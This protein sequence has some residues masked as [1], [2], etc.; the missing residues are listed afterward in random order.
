MSE[1]NQIILIPHWIHETLRRHQLN[2]TDVLNFDALRR[3][4]S[5]S[6]L[7]GFM[8]LNQHSNKLGVTEDEGSS[9]GLEWAWG[10]LKEEHSHYLNNTIHPLMN[11][12]MSFAEL[13]GRLFSVDSLSTQYDTPFNIYDLAP[14]FTGVVIYPGFFTGEDGSAQHEFALLRA[15]VKALYVSAP[16]HDVAQT[17]VFLRYLGLLSKKRIMV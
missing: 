17:S 5:A 6:D 15:L 12:E 2:I 7:T 10:N 16:F 9:Y 1:A 11:L 4:V 14:R 3:V 8:L 13:Q